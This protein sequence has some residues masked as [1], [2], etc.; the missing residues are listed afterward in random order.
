MDYNLNDVIYKRK[1]PSTIILKNIARQ[2][3]EGMQALQNYNIIHGNLRPQNILVLLVSLEFSNWQLDK[4]LNV[5]ITDAL[6]G[7]TESQIARFKSDQTNK[8]YYAPEILD[9]GTNYQYCI[10][11][12]R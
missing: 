3:V 6:L 9:T 11:S 1:E 2:I 12:Y 5:K 4:A 7:S 10:S 8:F